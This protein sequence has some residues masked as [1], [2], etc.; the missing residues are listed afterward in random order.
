MSIHEICKNGDTDGLSKLLKTKC[1]IEKRNKYGRT[2]FMVACYYGKKEIVTILLKENCDIEKLDK[3]GNNGFMLACVCNYKEIVYMLLKL[4]CDTE[5][6]NKWRNCGFTLACQWS[7]KET[8][9]ELVR[10]GC[11]INH[12]YFR[13]FNK[14]INRGFEL[15][16]QLFDTCIRFIFKNVSMFKNKIHLLPHDIR[17]HL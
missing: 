4:N 9:I 7:H 6:R 11:K 14:E 13:M 5:K 10:Y 3:E 2:G 8:I 16:T 12:K 15:R 1:D 17:K